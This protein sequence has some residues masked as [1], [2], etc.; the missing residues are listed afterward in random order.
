MSGGH[1][2]YAQYHIHHIAEQ[3]EHII[4]TRQDYYSPETIAEFNKA[5]VLLNQAYIYAQRIDW[6]VEGDDMEEDF[7]RRLK[8]ELSN[9]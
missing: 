5:V 4:E 3:I 2:D 8:E 7:H 1:F 9:D 6:L